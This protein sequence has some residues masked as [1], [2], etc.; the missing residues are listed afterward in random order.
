MRSQQVFRF[1]L[2]IL[3]ARCFIFLSARLRNQVDQCKLVQNPQ[4]RL[5]GLNGVI[6]NSYLISW[7]YFDNLVQSTK[8][9]PKVLGFSVLDQIYKRHLLYGHANCDL[10]RITVTLVLSVLDQICKRP[11]LLFHYFFERDELTTSYKTTIFLLLNHL[12]TRILLL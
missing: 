6:P 4:M 11:L 12:V 1:A 3:G 8:S 5:R 2:C 10:E 9:T 7:V